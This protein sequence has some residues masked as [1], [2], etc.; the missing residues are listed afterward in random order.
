MQSKWTVVMWAA[1]I[2]LTSLVAATRSGT[3]LRKTFYVVAAVCIV[4]AIASAVFAPRDL[5]SSETDEP[6]A[7]P[8]L[9]AAHPEARSSGPSSPTPP[10][11]VAPSNSGIV[12]QGQTGDNT[13]RH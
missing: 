6:G 10:V 9:T 12:T 13:I 2:G 7:P 5:S 3:P 11:I 8:G 1:G 4:A